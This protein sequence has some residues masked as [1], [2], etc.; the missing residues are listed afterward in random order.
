MSYYSTFVLLMSVVL[1]GCQTATVPH[2]RPDVQKPARS[3]PAVLHGIQSL[4]R[5]YVSVKGCRDDLR[6]ELMQVLH[7]QIPQLDTTGP[8]DGWT[9]EF[10]FGSTSVPLYPPTAAARP[11]GSQLMVSVSK[12]RSRIIWKTV[13][14][15][16][17]AT[18][19]AYEGPWVVERAMGLFGGHF[20]TG[21]PGLL[22]SGAVAEFVEAWRA[23]NLSPDPTPAASPAPP[24]AELTAAEAL[25]IAETALRIA[26]W[27][28]WLKRSALNASPSTQA[29]RHVWHVRWVYPAAPAG[30]PV[31]DVFIDAQTGK[32]LSC[33]AAG[34]C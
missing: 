15:G 22:L 26:G 3:E 11:D 24:R 20:E 1:A 29:G 9:L 28:R 5:V 13:V 32:V 8:V 18:A 14:D 21:K 2:D 6:A 23:A 17:E 34:T 27:S 25:T 30:G 7:K 33:H 16:R 31:G 4:T 19:V 10:E 12:C